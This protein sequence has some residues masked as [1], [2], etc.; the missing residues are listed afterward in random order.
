M[1]ILYDS[2]DIDNL[3]AIIKDD[4]YENQFILISDYFNKNLLLDNNL[5]CALNV[6]INIFKY[7]EQII[8]NMLKYIIKN[9]PA[10]KHDICYFTLYHLTDICFKAEYFINM[11]EIIIDIIN[12]THNKDLICNYISFLLLNNNYTTNTLSELIDAY[13]WRK[14]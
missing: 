4:N 8:L 13:N 11:P 5:I 12:D 2:N 6:Y 14:Q 7:N 1:S 3:R 9:Y 10:Y